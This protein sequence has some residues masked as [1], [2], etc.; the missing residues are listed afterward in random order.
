MATYMLNAAGGTRLLCPNALSRLDQ[1]LPASVEASQAK[2][3]ASERGLAVCRCAQQMHGGIGFIADFYIHLWYEAVTS[4]ALRGGTVHEHRQTIA[5][6]LLD[7]A[8][9][10]RLDRSVS[11]P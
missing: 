8:G 7:Q 11:W 4:W 2:S 3:F 9:E 10:V 5:S 1:G 6:A